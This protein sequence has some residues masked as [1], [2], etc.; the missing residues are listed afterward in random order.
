MIDHTS[1]PPDNQDVTVAHKDVIVTGASGGIGRAIC[2]LLLREGYPVCGVS[3]RM[4]PS[5]NTHK[6]YTHYKI[7]LADLDEAAQH[8][9]EILRE[10]INLGSIIFCAGVP[11]FGFLEQLSAQSIEDCITLNLLSPM[12]LTRLAVPVMKTQSSGDLIY[13]GSEAAFRPGRQGAAYCAAKHGLRGFVRAVREEATRT[14]LRVTLIN[15]G[16]V[17]T[18]FYKDQS[19]EPGPESDHAI[20]PDDVAQVIKTVLQSRAGT[21]FDEIRMTPQKRVYAFK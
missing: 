11:T 21:V 20:D 10:R 2:E 1:S 18:P 9:Q 16:A 5:L 6:N 14:G 15:P 17:R 13:I 12:L 7:D 3:R 8:F 4:T 19:F